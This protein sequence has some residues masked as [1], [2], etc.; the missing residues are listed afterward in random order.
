MLHR[1]KIRKD[2]FEDII[3]GRKTYEIRNGNRGFRAGDYLGLN[4]ITDESAGRERRETGRFI[5]AKVV[6]I[7]GYSEFIQPGYVILSIR[8]CTI[9]DG[10]AEAVPVYGRIGDAEE[11]EW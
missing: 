8:I 4:E 7:L 6:G 2:Y 3:E 1:L 10:G 5:L 11:S 9:T